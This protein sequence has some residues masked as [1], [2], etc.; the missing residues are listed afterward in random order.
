[1][2]STP[3]KSIRMIPSKIKSMVSGTPETHRWRRSIRVRVRSVFE[4]VKDTVLAGRRNKG[5]GNG[6]SETAGNELQRDQTLSAGSS[7][8]DQ[9]SD[10]DITY[11]DKEAID[12][13]N[14]SVALARGRPESKSSEPDVVLRKFGMMNQDGKITLAAALLFGK[15]NDIVNGSIVKI[16]EFSDNGELVRE[17]LIDLPVIMQP[18]AVTKAL[19]EKYIPDKFEYVDARRIVVNRYPRKAIREAVV[20]AI[21]HKQYECRE[22]VLIRVSTNNIEIYNPGELPKKWVAEDLVRRHHSVRRNKKMAEVFHEAG[23]SESWGKGIVMMFETCTENGNPPPEFTVRHGGLEVTFE[24]NSIIHAQT[25]HPPE[26]HPSDTPADTP[27]VSPGAPVMSDRPE[28]K[29]GPVWLSNSESAVCKMIAENP[30]VTASEMALSL[31]L[32]ERHIYRIIKDLSERGMI[33]RE[34][35]RKKGQW[36]LNERM[37]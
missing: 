25:I 10:M 31:G 3:W 35:S 4:R 6:T 9:F 13:F 1:L 26:P 16:G 29:S 15:P 36:K 19:F 5:A 28:F 14:K 27:Q 12:Y 30:R 11:I 20:N 37:L 34:G 22:P 2:E 7:W 17:E 32:S 23:F 24:A 33:S 18:D 8:T 21:V